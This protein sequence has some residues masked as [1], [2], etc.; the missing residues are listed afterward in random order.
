MNLFLLDAVDV[1]ETAD[2]SSVFPSGSLFS[3]ANIADTFYII[4]FINILR[5]PQNFGLSSFSYFLAS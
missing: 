4:S 3:S 1:D 2:V 5:Y